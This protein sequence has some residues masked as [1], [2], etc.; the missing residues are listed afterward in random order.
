MV[1][2]LSNKELESK[3]DDAIKKNSE[4]TRS[5]IYQAE[6]IS[7]KNIPEENLDYDEFGFL[8]KQ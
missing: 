5:I 2:T 1:E 7:Y 6:D 4:I 3:I 8:K